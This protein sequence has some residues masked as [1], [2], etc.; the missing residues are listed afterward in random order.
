MNKHKWFLA[1]VTYSTDDGCTHDQI[2]LVRADTKAQVTERLPNKVEDCLDGDR[3]LTSDVTID[4]VAEIEIKTEGV[5][6][7]H[8]NLFDEG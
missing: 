6:I 5:V 8:Y 2:E 4:R 7:P 3:E 1:Y